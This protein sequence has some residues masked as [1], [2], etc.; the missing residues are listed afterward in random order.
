MNIVVCNF[1]KR[2]NIPILTKT[3]ALF[4]LD[5]CEV[6]EHILPLNIPHAKKI[7]VH[8]FDDALLAHYSVEWHTLPPLDEPL[9]LSM[10]ECEAN[11][12]AMTERHNTPDHLSYRE[13]KDI[14]LR[15]V[16]YWHHALQR[17]TIDLC[18]FG[19]LPHISFDYVIYCLCKKMGIPTLMFL[20]TVMPDVT[21]LVEDWQQP[22]PKLNNRYA[23]LVREFHHTAASPPLSQRLQTYMEMQCSRSSERTPFYMLDRDDP[24]PVIEL[25]APQTQTRRMTWFALYRFYLSY[26]APRLPW[27]TSPRS[28]WFPLF[29]SYIR[30]KA[31]LGIEHPAQLLRQMIDPTVWLQAGGNLFRAADGI[32]AEQKHEALLWQYYE[33]HAS[34]PDGS[35]PYVYLP[36]HFQP[37]RTTLPMAGAF[38]DQQL[39]VQMVADALPP[40]V[41]LYVKEHPRQTSRGRDIMFYQYI[42]DIPT[43]RLIPRTHDTFQLIEQALAVVTATGTAGWEALFQGK[44][45]LTFGHNFYRMAPGVFPITTLESCKQ[46]LEAIYHQGAAPSL[47]ELRLFLQA[48]D[49]TAIYGYIDTLFTPITTLTPEENIR[50]VSEALSEKIRNVRCT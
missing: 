38:V 15:T 37:E 13:R 11:F 29:T 25:A 18:L 27:L 10:R 28:R 1:H 3:L 20:P 23:E 8:S 19:V 40:G 7:V 36:L 9:I 22:V 16:R 47:D 14:Y 31:A 45:V 6:V 43:I 39:I 34:P 41:L 5:Y 48:V 17:N 33:E 35:Q 46:A 2:G 21:F 24:P 44:P 4:D 12:L 30:R 42:L 26:L 32:I 49:E 50:N